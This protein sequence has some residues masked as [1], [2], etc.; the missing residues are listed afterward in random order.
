M[1]VIYDLILRA[2]YIFLCVCTPPHVFSIHSYLIVPS[3]EE[4]ENQAT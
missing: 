3:N 2:D 1:P 4:I